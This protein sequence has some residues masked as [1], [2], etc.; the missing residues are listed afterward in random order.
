MQR[1][2]WYTYVSYQ[3]MQ[4]YPHTSVLVYYFDDG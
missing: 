4:K 2:I 3:Y 1:I